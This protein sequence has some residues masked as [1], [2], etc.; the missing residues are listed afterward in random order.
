VEGAAAKV[1][2]RKCDKDFICQRSICIKNAFAFSIRFNLSLRLHCLVQKLEK[3]FFDSGRPR[4]SAIVGTDILGTAATKRSV[5]IERQ[6][7]DWI[8][9]GDD[10]NLL[11]LKN[12]DE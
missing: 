8:A 10:W 3:A 4:A 1:V 9:V 2:S 6:C 11:R 5:I 12:S 7:V